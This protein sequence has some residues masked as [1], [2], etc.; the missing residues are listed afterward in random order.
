M[1]S[2]TRSPHARRVAWLVCCSFWIACG[3][4]AEDPILRLSSEEA[5][6]KGKELMAVEK[7]ALAREHFAHAFQT[8]PNSEVGRDSLLLQADAYYLNGGETNLIRAE[9]KYRDFRN[10]YPTS[11]KGAYVQFQ[12]AGSLEQRRRKPDRDQSETIK[13][14]AAYEELLTL[15]P[16]SEFSSEAESG[17]A[18]LR[19]TLAEHVYLVARYQFRRGLVPASVNRLESL[20][21]EYPDYPELD[22]VLCMLGRGWQRLEQ[23]E[24]A[25]AT[26]AR[27]RSEYPGSE[28]CRGVKELTVEEAPVEEKPAEE[29]TA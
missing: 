16:T 4:V 29:E 10:R 18:R 20:V 22:K 23:T 6:A 1:R 3:E 7:Y 12:I 15:Y 2:L 24:K 8:A 19:V 14:I 17:I 11:E 28:P 25:A 13:A 27:L 26:F 5:F 21:D 9:S